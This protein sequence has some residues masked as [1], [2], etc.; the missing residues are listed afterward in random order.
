[1]VRDIN[2]I[3]LTKYAVSKSEQDMVFFYEKKGFCI[4]INY[5]KY[6]KRPL[7]IKKCRI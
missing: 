6:G 5:E 3:A 7:N 1:M 2:V 4:V